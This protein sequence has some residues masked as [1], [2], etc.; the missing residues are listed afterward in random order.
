MRNFSVIEL[1]DYTAFQTME[2]YN[3]F[4]IYYWRN[5]KAHGAAQP[6]DWA[7]RD[8][9]LL[10]AALTLDTGEPMLLMDTNILRGIIEAQNFGSGDGGTTPPVTKAQVL[11]NEQWLYPGE[12]KGKAIGNCYN[13]G[14]I[15]GNA[16]FG[17]VVNDSGITHLKGPAGV[18]PIWAEPTLFISEPIKI[19]FMFR[20]ADGLFDE[21]TSI[22]QLNLKSNGGESVTLYGSAM[23][24]EMKVKTTRGWG[25]VLTE[26]RST[27]TGLGDNLN[28]VGVTVIVTESAIQV[29]VGYQ[30]HFHGELLMNEMP[31]ISE[32]TYF[33]SGGVKLNN[34]EITRLR[35]VDAN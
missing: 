24:G 22:M 14:S 30:V 12:I 28:N 3:P 2:A 17:S 10:G 27:F 29:S 5:A 7:Q 35:K 16:S 15:Y 31:S 25:T 9:D 34:F 4:T 20:E 11:I 19:D 8:Q 32:L 21:D 13:E 33:I 23:T 1:I 18:R 6:G 26:K